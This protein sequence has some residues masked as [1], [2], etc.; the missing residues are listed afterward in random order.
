MIASGAVTQQSGQVLLLVYGI[1]SL[2]LAMTAK[3]LLLRA[4]H[5]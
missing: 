4:H 1:A 3:R 2:A 5:P